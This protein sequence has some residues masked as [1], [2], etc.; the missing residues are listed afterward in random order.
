MAFLVI[1]GSAPKQYETNQHEQPV[2]STRHYFINNDNFLD[3]VRNEHRVQILFSLLSKEREEQHFITSQPELCCRLVPILS[4]NLDA[5][6]VSHETARK[7]IL[8]FAKSNTFNQGKIE[9]EILIQCK[10]G[11]E[12]RINRLILRLQSN[13]FEK[14][15]SSG[16]T[17]SNKQCIDYSAHYS[18]ET[19]QL[20]KCAMYQD[21]TVFSQQLA[22]DHNVATLCELVSFIELADLSVAWKEQALR[23]LEA[24]AKQVTSK[25]ALQQFAT[26][27]TSESLA[28]LPKDALCAYLKHI[29]VSYL[30][31]PKLLLSV[32][33]LGL[34]ADSGIVQQLLRQYAQGLYIESRSQMEEI[35]FLEF[36]P[37]ELRKRMNM[38]AF[39]G[40]APSKEMI[41]LLAILFPKT[42]EISLSGRQE[43]TQNGSYVSRLTEDYS[44]G[45]ARHPYTLEIPLNDILKISLEVRSSFPGLQLLSFCKIPSLANTVKWKENAFTLAHDKNFS[46]Y[47]GVSLHYLSSSIKW[48]L[49]CPGNP[50]SDNPHWQTFCKNY[51][52]Y[53]TYQGSKIFKVEKTQG[54]DADV[55]SDLLFQLAFV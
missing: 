18:L 4:Q 19:M 41:K 2:N 53:Q 12:I 16:M 42:Q 44:F 28:D 45:N 32:S 10:D 8:A 55:R 5:G 35:E 14:M 11:K 6:K 52:C 1:T 43:Q 49:V 39:H 34:F 26:H 37:E 3:I 48:T 33:S 20:I 9:E 7:I 13:Y 47:A 38:I 21:K 24:Q 30:L 46:L 15:L 40:L 31:T 23:V 29:N 27:A 22:A 36:M 17:E 51:P 54:A 50:D 25:E